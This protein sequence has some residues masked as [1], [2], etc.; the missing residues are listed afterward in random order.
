MLPS[1]E[2]PPSAWRTYMARPPEALHARLLH[3]L[4]QPAHVGCGHLRLSMSHAA[5]YGVRPDIVK[6]VLSACFRARWEGLPELDFVV[7]GGGHQEGAVLLVQ[8]DGPIYPYSHIPLVPPAIGGAQMF[9]HHPQVTAYQRH[10]VAHW[11]ATRPY[12]PA[13]HGQ[14]EALHAALVRIGGQQMQATLGAL[15]QGLPI[16]EATFAEDRSVRV[17]AVGAVG[18]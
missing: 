12:L 7:L 6:G 17:R 9:V 3:H 14:A 18:A 11:L 4:T 8:L 2:A 5:A 16:F 10:E 1:R 15:A 13:L